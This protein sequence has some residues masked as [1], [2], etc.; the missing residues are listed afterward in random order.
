M[1]KEEEIRLRYETEDENFS[2]VTA[3]D[4]DCKDCDFK[5]SEPRYIGIC[6][7]YPTGKPGD[8]LYGNKC[9]KHS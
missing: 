3:N 2:E 6:T 1:G 4:L 8:V 9:E 5:Y 7:E